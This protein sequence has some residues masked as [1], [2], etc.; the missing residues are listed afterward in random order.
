M[1]SLFRWGVFFPAVFV[2]PTVFMYI[3]AYIFYPLVALAAIGWLYSVVNTEP[4][5]RPNV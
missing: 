1:S 3:G 5:N 4:D 2:F